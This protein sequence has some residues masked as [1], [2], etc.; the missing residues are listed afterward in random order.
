MLKTLQNRVTSCV[1][2][3]RGRAELQW[4]TK[5]DAELSTAAFRA[6]SLGVV[7]HLSAVGSGAGRDL[8]AGHLAHSGSRE[9]IHT[10]CAHLQP[11]SPSYAAMPA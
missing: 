3:S 10:V 11:A 4:Q 8:Q 1:H 9:P 6:G 5:L 7:D 2:Q